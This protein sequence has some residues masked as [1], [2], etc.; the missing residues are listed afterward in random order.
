MEEWSWY[1]SRN[2]RRKWA[3]GRWGWGQKRRRAGMEI[4]IHACPSPCLLSQCPV[5][6][7]PGTHVTVVST[8]N[9]RSL[10][11]N[12]S[13]QRTRTQ[14]VR[15]AQV[16]TMLRMLHITCKASVQQEGATSQ[17]VHAMSTDLFMLPFCLVMLETMFLTL[18]QMGEDKCLFA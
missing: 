15:K 13:V 10:H 6:P 12:G 9:I 8:H 17:S 18:S 7:V 3:N 14:R 11:M 4:D 5:C 16:R 1:S 2:R